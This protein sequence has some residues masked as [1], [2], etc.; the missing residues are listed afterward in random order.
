MKRI[1]NIHLQNHL[2]NNNGDFRPLMYLEKWQSGIS[3]GFLKI[4]SFEII[5]HSH[6]AVKNNTEDPTYP[7]LNF[8]Q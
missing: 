1:L 5:V 7:F 2:H 3:G 6:V 4:E 8:S